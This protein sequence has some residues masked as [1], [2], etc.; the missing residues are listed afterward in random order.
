MNIEPPGTWD[1][2][3][4]TLIA[5]AGGAVSALRRYAR[6][7]K[8]TRLVLGAAEGATAIFVTITSFLILRSLLPLS[9]WQVPDLGLIGVSGAI[10]HVGLRQAISWLLRVA[11]AVEKS[12]R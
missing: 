2:I 9:G 3:A 4:L 6:E 7:S 11:E 10:A 5:S 8:S 12:A 1:W